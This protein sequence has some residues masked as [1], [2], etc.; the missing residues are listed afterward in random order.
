MGQRLLVLGGGMGSLS[1]LLELTARPDWQ[2]RFASITVLQQGWRLGGKGASSVRR[3]PPH[4]IE[5]H[6]L[7]YLFGFYHNTFRLLR[8]CY[9]T[10]DGRNNA[11]LDRFEPMHSLSLPT[12]GAGGWSFHPLVLPRLPGAP[13]DPGAGGFSAKSCIAALFSL[14]QDVA[15]EHEDVFGPGPDAKL[16][17][18]LQNES[19]DVSLAY[20]QENPQEAQRDVRTMVEL[21]ASIAW[22]LDEAPAD[23]ASDDLTPR[24]SFTGALLELA[25]A[26]Q[27]RLPAVGRLGD[28]VDHAVCLAD[29]LVAVVVGVIRDRAFNDWF[30]DRLDTLDFAVWLRRH[31]AREST[32]ASAWVNGLYAAAFSAGQPIAAGVL[33]HAWLRAVLTYRGAPLYRM[34][35]GMGE[36][37]FGPVYEI[38]R[39]R[40]VRFRFF[41]RVRAV[42]LSP[43][44]TRVGS[45]VVQ[46]QV[47]LRSGATDDYRP[48]FD[49]DGVACW[50]PEPDWDQITEEDT[51]AATG[52]DLENWGDGFGVAETV[53]RDGVD[54]DQVLLGISVGALREVCRELVDD[55]GNPRFGAMTRAVGT[56]PTQ[57]AQLWFER[58]SSIASAHVTIPFAG[59]YDTLANMSHL[60]VRE[61]HPQPVSELAYICAALDDAEAPPSFGA[62]PEFVTRQ[63]ARAFANAQRWLSASAGAV[64]PNCVGRDGFDWSRLADAS[65]ADGAE[66]LKAQ[67]FSTPANPSD[68]YVIAARGSTRYRLRA[69][70]SGYANLTLAG[71]WT[72]TPLSI[73][74]LEATVMSGV[75]A[76]RA[77]DPHVPPP[78]GDW[79]GS[80]TPST[81]SLGGS[82]Q[83]LRFDKASAPPYL[84]RPG[85]LVAPPPV[86]LDI[87]MAE[88][89]LKA[90]RTQLAALCARD[91]GFSDEYQYEP[92]GDFV[93]LYCAAMDNGT[94]GGMCSEFDYG[95]WIPVLRRRRDGQGTPLLRVYTPFVWVSNGA[96]MAGGRGV[97]GYP[98]QIGSPMVM[99]EFMREVAPRVPFDDGRFEAET[100]RVEGQYVERLAASSRVQHGPLLTVNARGPWQRQ[101]DPFAGAWMFLKLLAAVGETLHP[102]VITAMAAMPSGLDAVFLKQFPEVTNDRDACYRAIVEAPLPV[103]QIRGGGALS[104]T[105]RVTLR[106]C[107]SHEFTERLGLRGVRRAG[108]FD[109]VDAAAGAWLSFA[110]VAACGSVIT[111]AV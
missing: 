27:Q 18:H 38:L 66:R 56:L 100:F 8:G 96:A 52:K 67:W 106:R 53:L 103:T 30:S 78:S 58:P 57:A 70:A 2:R 13:G 109:E 65:G 37:V 40:G 95:I 41:H 16:S 63:R 14:M 91:L 6:G 84:Y 34:K 69:D 50:P 42:K 62:D 82:A 98:K 5:E 111:R 43:D 32:V 93:V 15:V 73:G 61:R 110:A 47:R 22:G 29:L 90:D 12:R 79:L 77:L 72:L 59:P 81:D 20:L 85:E 36:T 55:P 76:A 86:T 28:A 88:F 99:P 19:P 108:A 25:R 44:R 87:G 80:A 49:V 21:G 97:F 51:A 10:L 64:W 74:C 3:E 104:P 11:W 60:L 39:R 46:Q 92:V 54:F 9:A 75:Y 1:A 107:E 71:D 68:R 4:R 23:E 7:H 45:V 48:T 26:I 35:A 102:D 24:V 94:P 33:V 31:G 89:V 17:G 101:T 105:A 83:N